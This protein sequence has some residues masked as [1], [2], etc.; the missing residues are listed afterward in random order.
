M[1]HYGEHTR[2][3]HLLEFYAFCIALS[4]RLGLGT[5]NM[6]Q[7]LIPG[8]VYM[9]SS[10]EVDTDWQ[11][12]FCRSFGEQAT[13]GWDFRRYDLIEIVLFGAERPNYS[14]S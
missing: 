11:K 3:N 6:S 12:S 14:L 10:T 9:L 7:H 4:E 8:S 5:L 1:L 13:R 2:K